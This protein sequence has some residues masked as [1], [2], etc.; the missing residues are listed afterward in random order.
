MKMCKEDGID[1]LP[2]NFCLG[3]AL[4][5]TSASIKQE[6]LSSG[7]HE[8][9]WPE[10]IHCRYWGTRAKKGHLDLLRP[11]LHRAKSYQ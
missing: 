8:R 1:V 7:L 11:N 9:T 10:A 3:Q 2:V 5:S 6:F 4:Q